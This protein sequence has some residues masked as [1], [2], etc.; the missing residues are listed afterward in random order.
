MS[1]EQFGADLGAKT[2]FEL[3]FI[4][5][6][7]AFAGI[8]GPDAGDFDLVGRRRG[9][10]VREGRFQCL[11][12]EQGCFEK[13]PAATLQLRE[14]ASKVACGER[15]ETGFMRTRAAVGDP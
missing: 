1:G 2:L 4:L 5:A 9:N 8:G 14:R 3:R 6:E 7:A 15:T 10:N 12:I 13:F 11:A